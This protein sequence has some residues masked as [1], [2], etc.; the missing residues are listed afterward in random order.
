[1]GK[2]YDG[3]TAFDVVV[4]EVERLAGVVGFQPEGHL[5]QFDGQGVQVHAVDTLTNHIAYGGAE[6]S[7]CGLLFTGADDGQLCGNAPSGGEQ[8]VARAAG[9][10]GHA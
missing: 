10:V 6:G 9:D 3:V 1:M 4:E 7:G 2:A 5:A 8:D